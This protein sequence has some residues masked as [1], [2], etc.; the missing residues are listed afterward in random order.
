M[1]DAVPDVLVE[2]KASSHAIQRLLDCTHF[3]F[4]GAFRIF[5]PET[6]ETI[7]AAEAR[8]GAPVPPALSELLTTHGGFRCHEGLG[9][10]FHDVPTAPPLCGGL[11]EIL[12][13]LT[14]WHTW[15]TEEDLSGE[16]V[17]RL[18]GEFFGFGHH[19]KSETCLHVLYFDRKGA[20]GALAFDQDDWDDDL[21]AHFDELSRG[22]NRHGAT[23]DELLGPYLEEALLVSRSGLA[24]YTRYAA[25][26]GGAS[27]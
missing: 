14:F 4:M 13:A 23:L 22:V 12:D 5:P 16:A 10:T 7:R 27:R 15:R 19:R 18:N 20:F 9:L 11:V 21:V 3:M 1:S 2:L 6:P 8:I 25:D 17:K 24:M 26:D